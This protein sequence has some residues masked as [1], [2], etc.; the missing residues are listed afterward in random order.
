MDVVY[1]DPLWAS[2][3]ILAARSTQKLSVVPCQVKKSQ[4]C[5]CSTRV[6]NTLTMRQ[7]G[8][9][10]KDFDVYN[11]EFLQ[12]YDDAFSGLSSTPKARRSGKTRNEI[13]VCLPAISFNRSGFSRRSLSAAPSHSTKQRTA[14]LSTRQSSPRWP[15]ARALQAQ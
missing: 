11:R 8:L 4:S 6:R 1:A 15:G 3:S 9:P 13:K 14:S 2:G 12:A 10:G 7:M 5:P